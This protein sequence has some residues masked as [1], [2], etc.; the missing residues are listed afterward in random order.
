MRTILILCFYFSLQYSFGQNFKEIPLTTDIKEVTVFLQGAQIF[1]T[2]YT[3]VPVGKSVLRISNLS[4]YIDEK[5]IHVKAKGDFTILSVNH[6]HNFLGEL[7]KSEKLDSLNAQVDGIEL[8]IAREKARLEVLE[9]KQSLLHEN[10]N[11]KGDNAGISMNQLRDAINFYES[12]NTRIKEEKIQINQRMEKLKSSQNKIKNQLRLVNDQKELPVGEIE[13][14]VEAK[15]QIN[16]DFNISYVVSNAG[17]FPKYD[18]RVHD[19]VNPLELNYKAEVFQNTGVDW[20]N[21]KLRFSNAQPQQ[22]GLLPDLR[23]WNLN[24]ARNTVIEKHTYQ[25]FQN[26]RGK[27]LDEEGMPL[28]GASIIIQGTNIGTVSDLSGNYDLTLPNGASHLA[29][30]FVGMES[31]TVPINKQEIN[32]LLKDDAQQLSEMVVTGYGGEL[33]GK[34]AGIKIRGSAS[35]INT[36]ATTVIENQTTMDIEI[37]DPYTI[38]SNGEKLLVELKKHSI[39]AIYEYY[40]VPK[41]DKD[42][43]LMAKIINWDQYNFLEG[44][45]NLYFEDAFVGRSILEA[46]SFE[47]TLNISM[48]RDK[49]IVLGREKKEQFYQKRF[50]GNIVTETRGFTIIVRNKKSHPIKLQI[51]DQLPVS[52]NSDIT[53]KSIDLSKGIVED[54]TGK[55]NWVLNLDPQQQKNLNFEYEVRYPR[56]EKV[57]LE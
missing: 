52:I 22:S 47:D 9:E 28:P 38:M 56:R 29:V 8:Q 33:Q 25:R 18:I 15:S 4:P 6:K 30:S 7:K 31:Q 44:E 10:K 20:K 36:I 16:G 37:N 32:V 2:G 5:S 43:F 11:L 39:D 26:V 54:P 41:I 19:V 13:I 21:V 42:A 17:W 27:I 40:A 3:V 53:V 14:R 24:F 12:E 45:A 34:V 46:K 49:N 50:F 57:M 51:F 55:V 1:E 23:T 35:P 48:G